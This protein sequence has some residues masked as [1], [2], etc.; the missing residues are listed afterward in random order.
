[1]PQLTARSATRTAIVLVATV[2]LIGA[3]AAAPA[4]AQDDPPGVTIPTIAL[5][6]IDGGNTDW[7][8]SVHLQ[9]GSLPEPFP[10]VVPYHGSIDATLQPEQWGPDNWWLKVDIDF[11]VSYVGTARLSIEGAEG[12]MNA[13]C[14]Q[15]S[16]DVAKDGNAITVTLRG[17]HGGVGGPPPG[18][19]VAPT[20]DTTENTSTTPASTEPTV[21]AGAAAAPTTPRFTG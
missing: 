19:E 14:T 6:V 21:A 3:T 10:A 7:H 20:T 4:W 1:V 15:G 12:Y 8:T 16:C 2:L 18:E 5:H 11:I 17:T 9:R 13:S